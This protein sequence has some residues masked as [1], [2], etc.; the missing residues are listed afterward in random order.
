MLSKI[1]FLYITHR[2]KS[3]LTAHKAQGSLSPCFSPKMDSYIVD[4]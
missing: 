1:S 3:V 2:F 4:I